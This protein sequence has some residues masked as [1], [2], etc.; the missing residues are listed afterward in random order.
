MH[1]IHPGPAQR[2]PIQASGAVAADAHVVA[3]S[4]S[5][6][7]RGSK[8]YHT[9]SFFLFS[10]VLFF[11]LNAGEPA[12][13]GRTVVPLHELSICPFCVYADHFT[14]RPI[15]IY[16]AVRQKSHFQEIEKGN[17]IRLAR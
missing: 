3:G 16:V 9:P 11:L 17:S 6:V 5:V 8:A 4:Q 15:R 12:C 7:S 1:G 2:A 14:H 13:P 10:I